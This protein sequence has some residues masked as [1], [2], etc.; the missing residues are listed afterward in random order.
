M[1]LEFGHRLGLSRALTAVPLSPLVGCYQELVARQHA[2][3]LR[4]IGEAMVAPGGRLRVLDGVYVSRAPRGWRRVDG[5]TLRQSATGDPAAGEL[6]LRL[7]ELH[8][9]DRLALRRVLL[10]QLTELLQGQ[11]PGG[12]DALAVSLGVEPGEVPALV[13]AA[14]AR[15]RPDPTEQAAAEGLQDAWERRRLGQAARLA[16]QLPPDG[17]EDPF[18]AKR[19]RQIAALVKETDD[20]LAAAHR[21]ERQGDVEGAAGRY[22]HVARLAADSGR[23]L[24]G[25]VRTHR[26][27]KGAPGPLAVELLAADSVRLSWADDADVTAWRI[28]RLDRSTDRRAPSVTEVRGRAT[29]G[30]AQDPRPPLG[31]EVRYAAF[32]LREGF[33]GG[34]PRVSAPLLVAPDVSGLRLAD[35]RERVTAT[36]TRPPESFGVR[37]VMTGPDGSDREIETVDGGFTAPGLR[38]GT[39]RVRVRCRYRTADGR[40]VESPGVEERVTVHPWPSPVAGLVATAQDGGVRF[41]WTGG[42]DGEVRL[43]EW[44]GDAP[45][46]GSELGAAISA[47][48]TPLAW[49][50]AAAPGVLV[51]PAG[52][53]VRVTAVAVR[54]ERA[55]AGPGIRVEAPHPVTAL[56]AERTAGG[57]AR[58]TF[59][60]PADAGQVTVSVEQDGHRAEHRVARSVFLREGLSLPVGPSAA[61][62]TATAVPRTTD[63][64][65]V[66]PPAAA[67]EL[68]ADVTVAY[69]VVAGS[70]R[71]LR[72]RPATVQISLSSPAGEVA[73]ELPEFVLVARPGTGSPPIRPRDP[74][75]GTTVLRLSGEELRR[76]GRVER[77]IAPGSCRPPYALRGFLLGGQ[78]ASVRLE[79]PSP[80]TLVVR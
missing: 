30:S 8:D 65:V 52:A 47:L 1:G 38:T 32:P 45:P 78:A 22:L 17:G 2:L 50:Q 36:W 53:V 35:G 24:R 5:A 14:G 42:E 59:A 68:P 39:Y 67:T 21:L 27:A 63:A 33:V 54:G 56:A 13:H 19:L 29:G 76:A 70:R 12:R 10:Y 23:A 46:P 61:R 60:W 73:A 62:L 11:P 71:P 41:S 64:T 25:L 16:A 77:E 44:P 15:R 26:P 80:A 20:S 43:V 49:P 69:R 28:I 55:V 31:A 9:R 75:D 57:L 58:I 79:E 66:P 34:P 6:L 72:R 3:G 4:H 18:L 51:P 7:A 48:P 40:E 37:A 74:A